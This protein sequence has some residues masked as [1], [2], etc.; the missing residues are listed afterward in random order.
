LVPLDTRWL[1]PNR[2]ANADKASGHYTDEGLNESPTERKQRRAVEQS[3]H[4]QQHCGGGSHRYPTNRQTD[5]GRSRNTSLDSVYRRC[6]SR[7]QRGRQVKRRTRLHRSHNKPQ[8]GKPE[9]V[10]DRVGGDPGASRYLLHIWTQPCPAP[11]TSPTCRIPDDCVLTWL[12]ALPSPR[13]KA[14]RATS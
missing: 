4:R 12:R 7:Y 9:R 14:R 6:G 2:H 8:Q 13:V 5:G 11:V 3:D 10:T 1:G